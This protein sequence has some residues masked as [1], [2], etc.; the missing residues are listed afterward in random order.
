MSNT[1]QELAKKKYPTVI[2][3]HEGFLNHQLLINAQRE[4]YIAGLSES[5]EKLIEALQSID[6]GKN[7]AVLFVEWIE[8]NIWWADNDYDDNHI[9]NTCF[10]WSNDSSCPQNITTE[11]LYQLFKSKQP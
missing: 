8:R 10:L 7:D 9:I 11:Q 3:P 1:L 6:E 5:N 2:Y 4:A